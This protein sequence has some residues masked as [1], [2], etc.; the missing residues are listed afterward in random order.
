MKACNVRDCAAIMKYFAYLEKELKKPDHT[1]DEYTGQ[2]YLG[3]LRTK[4]DLHQGPSFD[5]IS[6]I[7][8]NGAIIHY[9]PEADTAIRLNNNEIYLLDSG[10]QYLDGTTDI[11]RTTHFDGDKPPTD[12]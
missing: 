5:S 4:G 2:V 8:A 3:E 10:G 6:S 7:G 9:K 1:V 12:F 11:T